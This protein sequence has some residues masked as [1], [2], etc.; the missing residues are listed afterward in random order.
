MQPS[1]NR[2]NKES[3]PRIPLIAP[4]PPKKLD[5]PKKPLPPLPKSVQ[6][7]KPTEQQPAILDKERIG[8][9]DKGSKDSIPKTAEVVKPVIHPPAQHR[10]LNLKHRFINFFTE[11]AVNF[12]KGKYDFVEINKQSEKQLNDLTGSPTLVLALSEIVP[13]L[14]DIV[15]SAISATLDKSNKFY[16]EGLLETLEHEREL[17]FDCLDATLLKVMANLAQATKNHKKSAKVSFPDIISHLLGITENHLQDLHNQIADVEKIKDEKVRNQQLKAILDPFQQ[18]ILYRLLPNGPDDIMLPKGKIMN[19]LRT[20]IYAALKDAIPDLIIKNYHAV[21][22]PAF[23]SRTQDEQALKKIPEG[24]VLNALADL[25]A[26]KISEKVPG[27]FGDNIQPI[28]KDMAPKLFIAEKDPKQ[29]EQLT[30]WL[31]NNIQ[32]LITSDDPQIKALWNFG[33]YYLSPIIKHIILKIVEKTTAGQPL[34]ENILHTIS[35]H[36]L[37][38]VSN[39]FEQNHLAIT[40]AL[41]ELR[42][43]QDPEQK[44]VLE[45]DLTKLFEPLSNEIMAL[46]GLDKPEELPVP[47][48]LRKTI[49]K[50]LKD[51]I[52]FRLAK[53]YQDMNPQK[54]QEAQHPNQQKFSKF[55]EVLISNI[56]PILIDKAQSKASSK[57]AEALEINELH[58]DEAELFFSEFFVDLFTDPSA[59][60]SMDYLKDKGQKVLTDILVKIASL[61]VPPGINMEGQ[62]IDLFPNLLVQVISL[63][64]KHLTIMDKDILLRVHHLKKLP[65]D[66]QK[67]EKEKLMKHL[68]PLGDEL[69]QLAGFSSAQTLP[70]P[71]ELKSTLFDMLRLSL[72]PELLLDTFAGLSQSYLDRKE[73]LEEFSSEKLEPLNKSCKALVKIMMPPLQ[74]ALID[75]SPQIVGFI[76]ENL[77]VAKLPPELQQ[78]LAQELNKVGLMQSPTIKDGWEFIQNYIEGLMFNAIGSLALQYHRDH[79]AEGRQQ[80]N[81]DILKQASLQIIAFLGDELSELDKKLLYQ[82]KD[83]QE[84]SENEKAQKLQELAPK[85]QPLVLKI[86][87]N[88]GIKGPD[89]L[90]VPDFL[91]TIVW[92][93]LTQS[94]LPQ[95]MIGYVSDGLTLVPQDPTDIEE[96]QNVDRLDSVLDTVLSNAV[97]LAKEALEKDKKGYVQK[98]HQFIDRVVPGALEL[99]TV[100]GVIDQAMDP[101]NSGTKKLLSF[102]PSALKE[103][104]TPFILNIASGQIEGD[105]LERM[106]SHLSIMISVHFKD[107][108]E[109]FDSQLLQYDELSKSGKENCLEEVFSPFLMEALNLAGIDDSQIPTKIRKFLL[110]QT[111]NL[112][113]LFKAPIEI[114]QNYRFQLHQLMGIDIPQLQEDLNRFNQESQVKAQPLEN[115]LGF[116][117]DKINDQ[118]KAYMNDEIHNNLPALINDLLPQ[119]K[120]S[121]SDQQWLAQV[122]SGMASSEDEGITDLWD[123]TSDVLKSALMKIFVDVANQLP[124]AQDPEKAKKLLISHMLKKILDV[125]GTN[126]EGMQAKVKTIN[127][128]FKNEDEHQL[129]MRELFNPLAEEFFQLAGPDALAALPIPDPIK[130]SLMKVFQ[131]KIVPDLLGEMFV[132]LSKWEMN[133]QSNQDNLLRLFRNEN[134]AIAAKVIARFAKDILPVL[135][136]NPEQKVSEKVFRLFSD[137]MLRQPEERALEIHDYMQ[138]HPDEMINLIKQNF[139][140]GLDPNFGLMDIALP[141]MEDFIEAAIL[142]SMSNIFSKINER[143]N[144]D[145]YVDIGLKIIEITNDHF[146]EINRIMTAENKPLAYEVDANAMRKGFEGLH[147]AISRDSHLNPK[148]QEKLLYKN[149]LIP[150]TEEILKFAGIDKAQDLPLPVTSPA[151]REKLFEMLKRDLGPLVMESM[152]S[153]MDIDKMLLSTLE[154][155]NFELEHPQ[156]TT[157]FYENDE[158][159]QKINQGCGE[160]FLN[161]IKLIPNTAARAFLANEKIR[162]IPAASLGKIIRDKLMDVN[163]LQEIN[164]GI[165]KGLPLLNEQISVN[166]NGELVIPDDL[167]F[168]FP[169]TEVER[170]KEKTLKEFKKTTT[171][172]KLV[173]ELTKTLRNIIV[174]RIKDFFAANWKKLQEKI[175]QWVLDKFG[176]HAMAIKSALDKIFRT[177]FINI[178]GSVFAIIAFPFIRLMGLILNIHLKRKSQQIS[179]TIHMDIHKN[180]IFKLSE[181]LLKALNEA[182]ASSSNRKTS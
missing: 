154:F 75:K 91:K 119:K 129:A 165:L 56:T 12:A 145:L 10:P 123:Y 104:I 172:K 98:I 38:K 72:M 113:K 162:N 77:P 155:I 159:L 124:E 163:L 114:Q 33:E 149:F 57:L 88:I 116:V 128:Q 131:Q 122:F 105:I 141:A 70:G 106:I 55:A 102:I 35:T 48:F 52:P 95:L 151:I 27:L 120:L 85:F 20:R 101:K 181:A 90:A 166:E 132:D 67:I 9:G 28:L 49:F 152:M 136:A 89:N 62:P 143:K 5:F 22:D 81:L 21:M 69:L 107:Q 130:Q 63:S 6:V 13:K 135:I 103:F 134:P 158:K 60:K 32:Q 24:D 117:A 80:E 53:L 58:K 47:T 1:S 180:L 153:S 83:L 174:T 157:K 173:N 34:P 4:A 112:Y 39:F 65:P 71:S 73:I 150:M 100:E 31:S 50:M 179:D 144:P 17:I 15:F 40:Q 176:D 16:K 161:M 79:V 127:E 59:H 78:W 111:Y 37:S 44:R 126:L 146:K 42:A 25:I 87:N 14:T 118:I 96:L 29:L 45:S 18:D 11:T 94:I 156:K 168:R 3:D 19:K 26:K 177:I 23:Q 160:L 43:T 140:Q 86:F 97:P 74:A 164:K 92:E 51:Q 121:A 76:N 169:E 61:K 108:M 142:K 82:I 36:L 182:P 30:V 133:R 93:K 68:I 54:M 137:F 138:Q 170:I 171:E 175:D 41:E 66:E 178:I 147:P 64:K 110:A 115:M 125:L 167:H 8:K 148:E 2:T 109:S 46:T 7:P 139:S 84:L 99:A